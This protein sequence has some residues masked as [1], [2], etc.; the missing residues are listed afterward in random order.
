MNVTTRPLAGLP[1]LVAQISDAMSVLGKAAAGVAA[2]VVRAQQNVEYG[3]ATPD[4]REV[5]LSGWEARYSTRVALDSTVDPADLVMAV[6]Q[7][8]DTATSWMPAY[9]RSRV[10]AAVLRATVEHRPEEAEVS[11]VLAWHRLI[12]DTAVEVTR[13]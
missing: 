1:D 5:I 7:R 8:R 11:G 6:M 12:G 9:A 13:G 10:A 3:L 4:R 2:V